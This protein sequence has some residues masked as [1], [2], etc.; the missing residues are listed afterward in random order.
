MPYYK[1]N[2]IQEL[3]TLQEELNKIFKEIEKSFKEEKI[4]EE[5][6]IWEPIMDAL[7]DEEKYIF[8]L[9]LPGIGKEDVEVHL[10]GS[11]LIISGERRFPVEEKGEEVFLRSECH[12]GPFRRIIRIP[13]PFEENKIEASLKDGV[14][15]IFVY[16][17]L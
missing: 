14:L 6:F 1:L 7:E 12:Y 9:E 10:D 16:K 2:A 4:W 11:S 5:K 15:K 13:A 8:Y 17:K 3:I